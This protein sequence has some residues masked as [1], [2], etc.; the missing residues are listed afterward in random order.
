L[1]QNGGG[2]FFPKPITPFGGL[3]SLIEFLQ[4]FELA[5]QVS[6]HMQELTTGRTRLA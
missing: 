6:T 5:G 3:V 1:L 2:G 4:R